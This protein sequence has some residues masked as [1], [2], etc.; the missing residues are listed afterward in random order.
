[1]WDIKGYKDDN[2]KCKSLS[3]GRILMNLILKREGADTAALWLLQWLFK[4]LTVIS[5]SLLLQ[6]Y[7][8]YYYYYCFTTIA[9][10]NNIENLSLK[11][12]L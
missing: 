9:D 4:L 5:W 2:G 1:V 12:Y 7:Y 3:N 6:A 8:Y 11:L 10:I